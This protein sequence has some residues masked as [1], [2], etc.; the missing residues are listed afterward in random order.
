LSCAPC[1][2]FS[3]NPIAR[4]VKRKYRLYLVEA[5]HACSRAMSGVT[6][7]D[8]VLFVCAPAH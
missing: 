6:A 3:A 8:P 1:L 4:A 5:A 2:H 7:R